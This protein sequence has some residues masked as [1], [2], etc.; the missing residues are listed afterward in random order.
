MDGLKMMILSEV[1]RRQMPEDTA[2]MWSPNNNRNE[3]IYKIGRDSQMEK[4]HLW[5]PKREV[6]GGINYEFGIN[7]YTLLYVK[8]INNKDLL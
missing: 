7:K 4:T 1:R 2:Y 5:L 6:G 8:L 3:L